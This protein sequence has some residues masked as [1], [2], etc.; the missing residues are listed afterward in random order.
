MPEEQKRKVQDAQ[1]TT[2]S[3][4]TGEVTETP[5][6]PA[7]PRRKRVP[8]PE[9]I[10]KLGIASDSAAP[11]KVKAEEVDEK[12]EASLEESGGA[13]EAEKGEAPVVEAESES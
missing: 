1:A 13:L 10:E 7:V 11:E 6:R 12:A 9:I 8:R 4:E 5:S 2:Y 3:T